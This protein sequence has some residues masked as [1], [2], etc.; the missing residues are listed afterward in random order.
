MG[1]HAAVGRTL[2]EGEDLPGAAPVVVLAHHYW[3]DE[4][5]SRTDAIGR[6]LQIGRTF[7][8]VVGVMTPEIEFGNLAEVDV[9]LPLA[10]SAEE[11]RDARNLRFIARLKDG[12][13]FE[14]AAAEMASIG[15]AL[16]AE[17]PLSNGGWTMRLVPIRD[18]TGGQGFWVVIALF[19]LS[20]GLLVAIA[21]ANV[22]NLIMVRAASRARELAVRTAMGARSGRLLRQFVVEGFV[23][24]DAGRRAVITG[25]VAW[26]AGHRRAQSRTR[27]PADRDRSP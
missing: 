4:M 20:M 21:T 17:H 9:W 22:S 12:V 19:L 14:Q 13:P 23:L 16:A 18:I 8:T 6:T 26:A 15:A 7:Y 24:G 11:P 27:V 2:Q 10:L 1:Q 3:R 5:E 25:R